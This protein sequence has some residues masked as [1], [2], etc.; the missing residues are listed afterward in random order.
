MAQNGEVDKSVSFEGTGKCFYNTVELSLVRQLK[1]R[2]R[3]VESILVY[4]LNVE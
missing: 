4:E 1:L 2:V 3:S